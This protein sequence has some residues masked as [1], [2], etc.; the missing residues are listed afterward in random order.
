MRSLI[1]FGVLA[2]CFIVALGDFEEETEAVAD[3]LVREARE[4]GKRNKK[5]TRRRN[6]PKKKKGGRGSRRFR[7][8]KNKNNNKKKKANRQRKTVK[9]QRQGS[10]DCNMTAVRVV[11]NIYT[12]S[13]SL[14]RQAKQALK[15]YKQINN[16]FDKCD[17]AFVEPA[18]VLGEATTNGTTCGGAVAPPSIQEAY[19][20]LNNYIQL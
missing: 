11:F 4:A 3:V 19:I 12:R 18:K 9:I 16:K 6:R 1:L 8:G 15:I 14:G 17:T 2:L 5:T 7:K 10:T 13:I 20:N